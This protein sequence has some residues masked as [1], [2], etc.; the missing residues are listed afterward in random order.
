MWGVFCFSVGLRMC[1]VVIVFWI[2]RLMFMFLVGDMVCVV[3]L[4]YSRLL[5]Y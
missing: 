2:V 4:M 5:F 1:V 3:L